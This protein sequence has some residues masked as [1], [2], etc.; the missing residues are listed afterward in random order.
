M[1]DEGQW[2]LLDAKEEEGEGAASSVG[3]ASVRGE[4]K[5]VC[6]DE[7]EAGDWVGND[8]EEVDVGAVLIPSMAFESSS[9]AAPDKSP[10]LSPSPGLLEGDFGYSISCTLCV[11][12]STAHDYFS[13]KE[14]FVGPPPQLVLLMESVG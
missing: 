2:G 12:Q 3:V 1:S 9:A 13:M 7:D 11:S 10:P 8:S 5:G 14:T 6:S 4:D